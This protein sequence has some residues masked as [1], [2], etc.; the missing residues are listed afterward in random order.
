MCNHL[1]AQS[2]W[3]KNAPHWKCVHDTL[4][5]VLNF[6]DDEPFPS[7][8]YGRSKQ[9]RSNQKSHVNSQKLLTIDK[10]EHN[11]HV[12][13]IQIQKFSAVKT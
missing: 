10:D 2:L 13:A 8:K 5:T 6:E 1:I 4:V 3:K 11:G 7:Y 12:E 9:N